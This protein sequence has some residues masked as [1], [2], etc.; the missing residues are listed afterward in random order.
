MHRRPGRRVMSDAR[1]FHNLRLKTNPTP[2]AMNT[3]LVG[4]C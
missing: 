2:K 3:A 1:Y 4:F